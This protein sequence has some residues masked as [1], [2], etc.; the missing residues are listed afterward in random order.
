MEVV[1]DIKGILSGI[2]I[3]Q[4]SGTYK[5]EE[6]ELLAPVFRRVLEYHNKLREQPAP[7]PPVQPEPVV[8]KP[9][10]PVP[11]AIPADAH[12]PTPVQPRPVVS[13]LTRP[14]LS[15]SIETISLP[16]S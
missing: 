10:S 11:I 4:S 9:P 3:A 5:L 2:L 1:D 12:Q 8:A 7:S 6:S 16:I 14:T 15:S 13:E